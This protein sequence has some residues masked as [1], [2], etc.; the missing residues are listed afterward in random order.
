MRSRHPASASLRAAEGAD[1]NRTGHDDGV[2]DVA[3]HYDWRIYVW[4]IPRDT[5]A[6]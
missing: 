6:A 3:V 1:G 4:I 5:G 2:P